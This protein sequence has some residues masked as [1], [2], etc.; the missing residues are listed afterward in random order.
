MIDFLSLIW[1]DT[2]LGHLFGEVRR[3]R[4]GQVEQEWFEPWDLFSMMDLNAWIAR[5]D[6]AKYDVYYGVLPRTGRGGTAD[7]VVD[8]VNVVWADIDAKAMPGERG[9]I[10]G[11]QEAWIRLTRMDTP[12]TIIVDSG[13]GYHGYWMLREPIAWRQAEAIMRGIADEIGADRVYDK[14]RI[15]RVPG[16][17]NH[18]DPENPIPVRLVKFDTTRL[19]TPGSLGDYRDRGLEIMEPAR[20]MSVTSEYDDG[21]AYQGGGG[22]LPGWMWTDRINV[23]TPKGQRSEAAFGTLIWLAKYGQS[24]QQIKDIFT[25]APDGVG[26]KFWEKGGPTSPRAM[27]WLQGSINEARKLA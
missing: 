16:T 26:A 3:I 25:N 8:A 5:S 17:H 23:A 21:T 1:G 22:V 7:H 6:K 9:I 14:P 15:L 20:P 27:R 4:G 11:K 12:P 13:N 10:D 2:F 24:D 18:K 19:V